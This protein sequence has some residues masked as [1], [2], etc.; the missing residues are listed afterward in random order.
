MYKPAVVLFP[1]VTITKVLELKEEIELVKK[2]QEGDEDAFS[3]LYE[4]HQGLIVTEAKKFKSSGLD[5]EDRIQEG[6]SGLLEGIR[7]YDPEKGA[8]LAT[9]AKWWILHKIRKAAVHQRIPY[10]PDYISVGIKKIL[11]AERK[12]LMTK[13]RKPD[14]EEISKET[15]LNLETVRKLYA[16]MEGQKTIFLDWLSEANY[17]EI[18]LEEV[19]DAGQENEGTLVLNHIL[20]KELIKK[21]NKL[22]PKQKRIIQLRIGLNGEEPHTL[23]EIGDMFGCSRERVRQIFNMAIE[24]LKRAAM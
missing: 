3:M 12:L 21:I 20:A 14:P 11:I 8:T 22:P 16:I 18:N 7:R 10:L 15:K 24:K 2:A 19:L 6:T 4:K 17:S 23:Q 5:F 13:E 9:Y 1:K